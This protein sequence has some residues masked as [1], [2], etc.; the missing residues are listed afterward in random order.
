MF[1]NSLKMAWKVLRRRR[2]FTFVSLFGIGFTLTVL[3]VVVAIADFRLAPGY[4]ETHLD[5]MLVLDR[6]SMSGDRSLWTAGPGFRFI[7]TYARDLSGVE[8]MTV[9]SESFDAVSFRNGRKLTFHVRST[10]ADYWRVLQF[11]F[12]EGGPFTAE[13]DRSASR[14]AVISESARRRFFDGGTA[15]GRNIELDGLRFRVAGVV[16]D[17]PVYR[18]T[19]D[20][21]IWFPLHSVPIAGFF[22][23]FIGSCNVAYLLA[24]G[25]DRR[26]VQAAFRERL[27]RVEFD[28]PERFHTIVGLPMTS[29]EA[30]SN[31]LLDLETGQTAP[32][33]L[34]LFACLAALAFMALPAINLVNINLSR[35]SERSGEIGVRKAFGASRPDLVFQFVVENLVLSVIGGGIGLLG[36]FLVLEAAAHLPEAPA[37]SFHLNWRIFLAGFGLSVVFGL[38][39]GVWPAWKM[40]RQ[41]PV[42]ALRGG[43]S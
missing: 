13:D 38:L 2:F 42:V 26:Q 19:A 32:R 8:A 17:V 43:A 12:L 31:Q 24:E 15:L 1:G 28:D 36:A 7:D 20:A 35:I 21:D 33:R 22:D 37:M 3:M 40:S 10:D 5:R 34:V 39:S 25:T 11:V 9:Y 41:H 16:R 29:L 14:V 4:P 6:L 18:R 30:V 23:Q 27:T